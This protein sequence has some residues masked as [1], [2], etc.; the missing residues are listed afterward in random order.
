M[1]KR[2][3][4][5]WGGAARLAILLAIGFS[6]MSCA[7]GEFESYPKGQA[8][9]HP[10]PGTVSPEMK[11]DCETG[12]IIN[13]ECVRNQE[14]AKKWLENLPGIAAD[15]ASKFTDNYTARKACILR[16]IGQ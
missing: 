1:V 7:P 8:R 13:A 2:R 11:K 4:G 15:C 3:E 12:G 5:F 16:R 6:V 9:L 14:A 10:K